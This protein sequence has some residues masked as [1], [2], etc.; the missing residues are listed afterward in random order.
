MT[1][2][3]EGRLTAIDLFLGSL[4]QGA[5]HGLRHLESA[6][7]FSRLLLEKGRNGRGKAQRIAYIFGGLRLE[8]AADSV[9]AVLVQRTL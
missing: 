4:L 6:A 5:F 3:K 9:V 8:F 2:P 1:M 7:S